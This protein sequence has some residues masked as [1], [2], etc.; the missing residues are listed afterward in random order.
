MERILLSIQKG[1]FMVSEILLMPE[2]LKSSKLSPKQENFLLSLLKE[3]KTDL[4]KDIAK[5]LH[6]SKDEILKLVK[7]EPKEIKEKILKILKSIDLNKNDFHFEFQAE[8]KEKPQKKQ[9]SELKDFLEHFLPPQELKSLPVEKTDEKTE[10]KIVEIIKK[11]ITSKTDL[12]NF[13]TSKKELQQFKK[14][15]N[16]KDLIA[17]ANKKGLNIKKITIS[18]PAKEEIIKTLSQNSHVIEKTVIEIKPKIIIKNDKKNK[19]SHHTVKILHTADKNETKTAGIKKPVTNLAELLNPQKTK[20]HTAETDIANIINAHKGIKEQIDKKTK[21][22]KNNTEI[23]IQNGI[24]TELKHNILK[25]KETLK[26]FATNLKEAVENYKPPISK[27]SLELHPKELGKVEI[28]LIQRGDNL[29][30]HVNGQNQTINFFN[31]Y[32][33]DLKSVLVN[34]GYSDVNMSFNQQNQQKNQEKYK[35]NQQ[36]FAINDEDEFVI[37]IPYQYA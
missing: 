21:D 29:Q 20:K 6:L 30:I 18:K 15:E 12:K 19:I 2:N 34:M 1:F 23:H 5:N 37:E 3:G 14:I 10:K 33:Q 25:A 36:N 7:N 8:K 31:Q 16:I 13:I 28:T 11:E 17:F 35:Q 4:F 9:T 32:Q 27:V 24:H 26:H 22:D